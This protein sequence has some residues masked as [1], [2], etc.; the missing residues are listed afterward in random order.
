MHSVIETSSTQIFAVVGSAYISE[1]HIDESHRHLPSPQG[2]QFVANFDDML[3]TLRAAL[4]L[5]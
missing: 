4:S 5:R 3:K 2:G 1:H